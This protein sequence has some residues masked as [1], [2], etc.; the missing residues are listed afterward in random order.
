MLE[1]EKKYPIEQHSIVFAK[2]GWS[3]YI[4]DIEKYKGG[5]TSY[6]F[7]GFSLEAAKYLSKKK[8]KII[9]IDTLSLDTG[10]SKNFLV[11]KFWLA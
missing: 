1:F 4:N 11:H 3:E 5:K 6:H 8:V 2:T 7:P 9:G 10:C